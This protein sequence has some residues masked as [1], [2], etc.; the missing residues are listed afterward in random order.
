MAL[1]S[2]HIQPAK[3]GA[4]QHDRRTRKM[5][6]IK[7]ELTSRN[8]TWE[9]PGFRSVSQSMADARK[10]IKEKTGRSMQA[11]AI[12]F[13]EGVAVITE[14]TSIEQLQKFC[15]KCEERWGIKALAI[16]THLDEGHED[17]E[18][19][20]KGNLHAHIIWQWY[21]DETG[22]SIRHM[23]PQDF[24]KMQTILAKCL[25]MERGKSSDKEHLSSIQFKNK[26]ET[27]KHLELSD[28]VQ[29]ETAQ[30]EQLT[31]LNQQMTDQVKL[32]L[33]TVKE[34]C[35][36]LHKAGKKAVKTFDDLVALDAAKPSKK[37]Q[38]TRNNLENE[39][40]KVSLKNN[41]EIQDHFQALTTLLSATIEAIARIGKQ[42]RKYASNIPWT[43]KGRLAH[44]AEMEHRVY[45]AEMKLQEKPTRVGVID[46]DD[47]VGSLLEI[48]GVTPTD[49]NRN[50][51]EVRRLTIEM[52]NEKKM[53]QE[54]AGHSERTF[55]DQDISR[56]ITW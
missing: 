40:K 15:K 23:T 10:T 28:A 8:K 4:E 29:K 56:G 7:A 32:S 14:D 21:S 34:Q 54:A 52:V 31:R 17:K 1:T 36:N 16:Y 25:K 38:E 50:F 42:L 2:I 41:Q 46:D 11:K 5:D 18:G 30:V 6:H 55:R 35:E 39:C 45:E 51:D 43:K 48:L 33:E 20:W 12:P 26:A 44:E 53:W 24:S 49:K 19:K 13:R 3:V 37:E 47:I 27:E 9:A 22:K